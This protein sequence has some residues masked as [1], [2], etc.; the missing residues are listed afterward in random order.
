MALTE[1][2]HG[3]TFD[4]DPRRL[5]QIR[6]QLLIGPVRPIEPTP[7]GAGFHPRLD[8]R[9]QR[10]GN[11]TLLSRSPVDLDTLRTLFG[12]LCEPQ[13]HRRTM[14]PQILG[15]GLA[16]PPAMGHE[17]RL[18]P[19]AESSVMGRFEELF[20]VRLFRC[21]QSDALHLSTSP[22]M[23]NSMKGYHKKDANSY[24]ACMRGV[25]QSVIRPRSVFSPPHSILL[26]HI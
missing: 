17:D 9:C 7:L 16:L 20:Q 2:P 19:V 4:R 23:R 14:Y 5:V 12:I 25:N 22:L 8:G 26:A 24:A 21:G 15:D 11:P 6:R 13:A 3:R 18:A 10:L 1:H